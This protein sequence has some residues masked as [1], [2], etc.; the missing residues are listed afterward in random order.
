MGIQIAGIPGA[1]LATFGC[2]IS[3]ICISTALYTFFRKHSESAYISG[4]LNG[5][6]AASLGLIIS[7]AGI[8]L[9]LAFTGSQSWQVES[10]D[11]VAVAIFAAALFILRKWKLNPILIIA[12]TAVAGYVVDASFVSFVLP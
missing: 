1:I 9:L 11:L 2:V 3:G 7:A 12:L 4:I 5:L 10:F 6:K 8:I